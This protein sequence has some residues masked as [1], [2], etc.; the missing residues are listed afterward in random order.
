MTSS[1]FHPLRRPK[2]FRDRKPRRLRICR[3][4]R[5]RNASQALRRPGCIDLIIR[6]DEWDAVVRR[7]RVDGVRCL[8]GPLR[9][10]LRPEVV[11]GRLDG[12]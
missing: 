8:L 2:R 11:K 3:T 9:T 10:D 7:K 1:T 6:A 5:Q 4:G 12:R